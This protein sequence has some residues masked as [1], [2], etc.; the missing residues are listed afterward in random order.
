MQLEPPRQ[1]ETPGEHIH[2]VTPK[3]YLTVGISLL[4]LTAAT[5][6]ISYVDLGVFNAVVAMAIACT[7]MMLVVLFFMHIKYSNKLIKLTVFSGLFLFLSLVG[8]I[9]SDYISRAWGRW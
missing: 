8:M 2:I 5:C 1:D 3:V 6:G 9:M 4:I 7:K